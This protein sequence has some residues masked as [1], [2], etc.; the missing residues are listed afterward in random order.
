MDEKPQPK[1]DGRSAL[2]PELEDLLIGRL[3]VR[4]LAAPV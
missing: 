4:S 3:V 2:P 1:D